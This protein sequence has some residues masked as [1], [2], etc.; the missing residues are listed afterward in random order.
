MATSAGPVGGLCT[1]QR[2]CSAM[3][4]ASTAAASCAVSLPPRSRGHNS[5][6]RSFSS[7][8]S[9]RNCGFV[10]KDDFSSP[11]VSAC[12]SPW[13]VQALSLTARTAGATQTL[14]LWV[15]VALRLHLAPPVLYLLSRLSP[16]LHRDLGAVYS[17]A[18]STVPGTSQGLGSDS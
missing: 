16:P 3:A 4:G 2:R 5:C 10:N 9:G 1:T 8:I 14:G 7:P 11:V 12:L 13:T 17:L 15:P 18:P 6:V